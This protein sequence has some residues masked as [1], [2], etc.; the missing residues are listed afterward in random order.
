[1]RFEKTYQMIDQEQ[2][3]SGY[4]MEMLRNIGNNTEKFRSNIVD[5]YLF[6]LIVGR[7]QMRSRV[8]HKRR[9]WK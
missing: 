5:A 9:G 8:I 1:M 6:G 7:Q 3:P 2:I 4:N